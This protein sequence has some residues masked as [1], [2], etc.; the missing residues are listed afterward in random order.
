MKWT[1]RLGRG[2]AAVL[3]GA[4]PLANWA[5]SDDRLAD[6]PSVQRVTT[7]LKNATESL[8]LAEPTTGSDNRRG[9]SSIFASARQRTNS[10]HGHRIGVRPATDWP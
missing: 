9:R 6:M 10:S 8:G 7:A 2:L 3:V 4:V 5:A 1:Y